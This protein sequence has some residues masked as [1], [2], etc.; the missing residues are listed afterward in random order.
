MT[1]STGTHR[2]MASPD[3]PHDTR[4]RPVTESRPE[5]GRD[6]LP[7]EH[8]RCDHA[9]LGERVILRTAHC[10]AQ[11]EENASTDPNHVV[12]VHE[13]RALG[14]PADAEQWLTGPLSETKA[15]K[16][17][18]CSRRRKGAAL[19]R[20]GSKDKGRCKDVNGSATYLPLDDGRP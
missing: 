3:H 12:R 7:R 9:P 19:R 17:G 2:L 10:H 5:S 11:L 18:A 8:A 13:Q 6:G 16:S 4:Q 14:L 1:Q 15:R 20:G